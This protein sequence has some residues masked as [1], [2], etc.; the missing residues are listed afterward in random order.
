MTQSIDYD[1]LISKLERLEEFNKE[2]GKIGNI[3]FNLDEFKCFPPNIITLLQQ[4]IS[5]VKKLVDFYKM[6][7]EYVTNNTILENLDNMLMC[8][9]KKNTEKKLKYVLFSKEIIPWLKTTSFFTTIIN[10]KINIYE[11]EINKIKALKKKELSNSE[12]FIWRANQLDAINRLNKNGLEKGIHCQATGTGKSYII[13]HYIEYMKKIKTNPKIILFTERVNILADLFHFKK[14]IMEQDKKYLMKLK[15]KG[16]CDI[17]DFNIINRV[18]DKTKDWDILLKESKCP[19]LLVINRAFLTVGNTVGNTLGNAKNKLYKK[20]IKNDIDLILHDEC[21]NTTSKQCHDFLLHMKNIDVPIVGFSATPLRTGKGDKNKLLEIYNDPQDNSILN[22]LTNY[23]MIYSIQQKLILP[24]EFFW[25]MIDSTKKNKQKDIELVSQEEIGSVLELL[26]QIIP[27]LP[28]KKL[29]AWC[30][31]IQ[32]ANEWK[33]KFE[34]YY[35]QRKNMKDFTF[36]LD[37]SFSTTDDYEN[38]KNSNGKSIL[39]CAQKHREGSDIRLLDGC[40]FLDK[41]KDRGAIPFIQSI[42]R[43]LRLCPE[44]PNKTKG[45][46]ID[47]YVKDDNEYEK[48]FID[49]II[50]YYIVLL[51]LTDVD[52]DM[53]EKPIMERYIQLLDIIKFDK[54]KELVEIKFGEVNICINCNKLNW[55]EI[56]IKFEPILQQKIRLSEKDMFDITIIKL[57]NLNIFNSRTNFWEVYDNIINKELIGLP[58]DLYEKYKSEFDARTIYDI[59]DIDMSYYYT[60]IDE[61]ITGIK[62]LY[63]GVV[64]DIIYKELL[65]KDNKLPLFPEELYKKQCFTCIKNSFNT[66]NSRKIDF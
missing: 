15:E 55:D 17:T 53:D 52:S 23:N 37:T 45:I 44:T 32:L 22:L 29:V 64:D 8:I 41:V 28:Y 19:T 62:K 30:G 20:I 12:V 66:N 9:D 54:V 40:I 16:I 50:G 13:L 58:T 36:G 5:Y 48:T 51:N 39:F 59:L 2:Y 14:G 31:T 47:G 26:N 42:G 61:C 3:I 56:I 25:Y 43:V 35:K 34:L 46:V 27:S 1:V 21:H 63:K 33:D 60:T 24:P 11:D 4:D 18:T 38:F 10:D 7:A 49:K 57:K 6:K 65:N